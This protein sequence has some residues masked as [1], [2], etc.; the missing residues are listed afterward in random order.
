MKLRVKKTLQRRGFNGSEPLIEGVVALHAFFSSKGTLAAAL[1]D[2]CLPLLEVYGQSL[3]K[4]RNKKPRVSHV[5]SN[6]ASGTAITK[7]AD[8]IAAAEKKKHGVRSRVRSIL[9]RH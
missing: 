7:E 5:Y 1:R 6:N 2:E 9:V 8:A 3:L 4:A